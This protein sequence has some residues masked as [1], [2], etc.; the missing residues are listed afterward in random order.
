MIISPRFVRIDLCQDRSPPRVAGIVKLAAY[1]LAET[2]SAF[3][4][5]AAA[6]APAP[7]C[8]GGIAKRWCWLLFA[9]YRMDGKLG[10]RG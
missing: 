10:L 7:G 9:E 8:A 4:D 6:I 1:D 5:S 2:L 3:T